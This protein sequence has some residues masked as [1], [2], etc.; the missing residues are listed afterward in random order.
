M[1][2]TQ[3]DLLQAYLIPEPSHCVMSDPVSTSPEPNA[4]RRAKQLSQSL[5]PL[6]NLLTYVVLIYSP[7]PAILFIIWY[8]QQIAFGVLLFA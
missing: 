3:S 5:S 1:F 2:L 4:T 7:Q 6:Y 8:S